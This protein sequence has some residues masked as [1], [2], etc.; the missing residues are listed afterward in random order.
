MAQAKCCKRGYIRSYNGV[1]SKDNN[2]LSGFSCP[3]RRSSLPWC[4]KTHSQTHNQLQNQTT[5]INKPCLIPRFRWKGI[6]SWLEDELILRNRRCTLPQLGTSEKENKFIL[7]RA[8]HTKMSEVHFKGFKN[9][10]YSL[11]IGDWFL[12]Q[13]VRHN[14]DFEKRELNWR[15]NRLRYFSYVFVW[16]CI[17]IALNLISP[18]ITFSFA[19][20]QTFSTSR[21]SFPIFLLVFFRL[22]CSIDTAYIL[23]L[24]NAIYHSLL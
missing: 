12:I 13:S 3:N 16:H 20:Q 9:K 19:L 4:S 2:A 8:I 24:L 7:L 6:S 1:Y 14:H 10:N 15:C 21:I 18:E 5:F 11:V 22:S 17:N 23:W